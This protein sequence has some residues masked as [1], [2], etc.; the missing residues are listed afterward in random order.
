MLLFSVISTV[1]SA[2]LFSQPLLSYFVLVGW[3][4]KNIT[5]F[6]NKLWAKFYQVADNYNGSRLLPY[7]GFIYFALTYLA[8]PPKPGAAVQTGMG[9]FSYW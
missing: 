5:V 1:S 9:G 6:F 8:D 4:G 2:L 3:A 7:L